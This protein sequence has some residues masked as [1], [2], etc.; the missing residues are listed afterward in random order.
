MDQPQLNACLYAEHVFGDVIL[1]SLLLVAC[2]EE[3]QIAPKM[4]PW[5]MT[6]PDPLSGRMCEW[7]S[8]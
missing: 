8:A 5:Q 6:L 7:F 1:C 4:T 3:G 2:I